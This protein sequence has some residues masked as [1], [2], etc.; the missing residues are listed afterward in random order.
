MFLFIIIIFALYF[1]Y[2][3]ENKKTIIDKQDVLNN[4]IQPIR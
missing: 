2:Y 1:F 3:I 4:K